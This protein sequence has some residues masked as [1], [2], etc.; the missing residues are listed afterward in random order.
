MNASINAVKI[1]RIALNNEN[2][3]GYF[4]N[5]PSE[6]VVHL[7]W[8]DGDTR[9]RVA[10]R[11]DY[12]NNFEMRQMSGPAPTPAVLEGAIEYLELWGL[13]HRL[14][15]ERVNAHAVE[16]YSGMSGCTD[17]LLRVDKDPMW[18]DCP[19]VARLHVSMMGK[20]NEGVKFW[21]GDLIPLAIAAGI[22]SAESEP[23]NMWAVSIYR[24]SKRWCRGTE[25]P[26][27]QTPEIE[28]PVIEIVKKQ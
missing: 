28:I 15:N 18:G 20:L 8:V 12:N 21:L 22:G 17:Y 25:D 6:V 16:V 11:V 27:T 3:E 5:S 2:F 9:G 13:A 10:V 1:V 19:I 23:A 14:N 26:M 7:N 24:P 4:I